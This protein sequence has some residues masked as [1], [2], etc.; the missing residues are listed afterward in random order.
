VDIDKSLFLCLEDAEKKITKKTKAMVVVQSLGFSCD[1]QKYEKFAKKNN[2]KIIFDSAACL[3]SDYNNNK[4]IGCAGDFEIFS[5]HATKTFG[6]GEG[7]L[8]TSSNKKNLDNCRKQINFGFY[9]FHSIITGTNA[10]MSEIQASIGLAVLDNIDKK[11]KLRKSISDKYDILFSKINNIKT[12]SDYKSAYQVYP[13]L[14]DSKIKRDKIKRVLENNKIGNRVYYIPLDKHKFF[15]K[16]AKSKYP[17]SNYFYD[18]ILCIP[19]FDSLKSSDINLIVKI[20]KEN[21]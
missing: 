14:F 17:N 11:I 20:I 15:K 18:R 16:Y 1:Y 7:G 10:K 5:L 9:K 2:L 8:L 3:G 4:K 13:I 19:M 12:F 6:I 21:L